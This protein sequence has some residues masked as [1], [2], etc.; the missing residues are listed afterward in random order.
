VG[1]LMAN[2]LGKHL[3]VRHESYGIEKATGPFQNGEPKWE[4]EMGKLS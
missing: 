4:I 3:A 1:E 2:R